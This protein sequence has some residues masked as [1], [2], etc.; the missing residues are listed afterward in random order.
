MGDNSA[1]EWTDSTWNP[2][3]A[4]NVKTGKIGWHCEHVSEGCR[5]CYAERQN[6]G[7]FNLGTGLPYK[8][9]SRDAV[10]IFIDE[11][12]LGQPLRWKRPRKIFVCSMTDLF[13][14]WVTNEQIAA[15]F[16]VMM[17]TPHHTYQVLTKRPERMVEWFHWVERG[18]WA[19]GG[20]RRHPREICERA[21]LRYVEVNGHAQRPDDWP[22]PNVWLGVSVENE[23]T[24]D[25]ID[26]LFQVDAALYWLSIEPLL[27]PLDIAWYLRVSHAC[28][29]CG[30]G[31]GWE[32]D[33]CSCSTEEEVHTYIEQPGIG[34]VVAGGESGREARPTHPDWV[35][36]LREQ[37]KEAYIPF[38]FKQW[39]EWLPLNQQ[40]PLQCPDGRQE[41]VWPDGRI[42]DGTEPIK[43]ECVQVSRVG[44]RAAGRLLDGREWNQFPY[45]S[46]D[47]ADDTDKEEEAP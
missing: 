5:N 20:E 6:K 40:D 30:D 26:E 29:N 10:E 22:L 47:D 1:I 25:R 18:F 21:A 13:G 4:R 36:S 39:G 42:Y 11:A 16:G 14:S 7:F 27:G 3:R 35:R 37:C 46:A 41:H 8:S 24:K 34:W 23:G 15:I 12:T 32:G 28:P 19:I 31:S 9:K 45:E 2:I 43:R 33:R 38:F 44:K 17:A